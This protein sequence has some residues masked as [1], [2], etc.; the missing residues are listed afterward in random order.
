MADDSGI[1]GHLPARLLAYWAHG[2]GAAKWK[3]QP[4]PYTALVNALKATKGIPNRMIHGLAANIFKAGT[5]QYPGQRK[6]V[7]HGRGH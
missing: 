4:H 6:D 5:G 7:N 1:K 2:A 3:G